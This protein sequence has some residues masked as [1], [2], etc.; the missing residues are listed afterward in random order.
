MIDEGEVGSWAEDPGC[1]TALLYSQKGL[2]RRCPFE[3]ISRGLL[4]RSRRS[5]LQHGFELLPGGR[6]YW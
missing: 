6:V 4:L 5:D 2:V 3:G 1:L